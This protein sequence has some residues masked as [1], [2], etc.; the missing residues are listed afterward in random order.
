MSAIQKDL[1]NCF[2]VFEDATKYVRSNLQEDVRNFV[3]DSKQKNLDLLF[4]FHALASVPLELARIA[5]IL[6]IKKT[7][8]ALTPTLKKKFP[9]AQFE[10]AFS[11]VNNSKDRYT[12]KAIHL[13]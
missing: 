10:K 11:A 13:L 7:S 2:V 3:L 6:V 9:T 5:D 4:V 12:H 8:E 1:T